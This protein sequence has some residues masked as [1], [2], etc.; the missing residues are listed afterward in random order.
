MPASVN[1]A[2]VSCNQMTGRGSDAEKPG[3]G[4]KVPKQAAHAMCM[5]IRSATRCLRTARA[6]ADGESDAGKAEPQRGNLPIVQRAYAAE[7]EHRRAAGQ[8]NGPAYN[9]GGQYADGPVCRQEAIYARDGGDLDRSLMAQWMGKVGF[10]SSNCSRWP[11]MCWRRSSSA[12]GLRRGDDPA[13]TRPWTRLV[14][15]G[16]AV[17]LCARRSAIFRHRPPMV[18]YRFEDSWGG[19]CVE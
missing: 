5:E 6:P 14:A 12:T 8:P 16:L 17:G 4:C 1:S 2:N 18:A 10:E 15:K 13:N 9:R 11:T 19:E 7:P 3:R